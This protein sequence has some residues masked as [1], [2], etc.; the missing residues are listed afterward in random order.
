[1]TTTKKMSIEMLKAT[2]FW[3]EDMNADGFLD[4]IDLNALIDALF[5]GG[6]N[7]QDPNCPTTRGDFNSDGFPDAVDLNELI[8]HLFFSGPNPVDP[9]P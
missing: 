9:C 3:L 1:M 5:F 7:P 2:R 6:A 4:S 8:E